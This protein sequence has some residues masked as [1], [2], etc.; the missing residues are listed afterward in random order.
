MRRS[1]ALGAGP[2][3]RAAA[4]GIATR[5]GLLHRQLL[6]DP[7]GRPDDHVDIRRA[8]DRFHTEI[9]WLDSHHSFTFGQ[10]YDPANTHYGLLLVTNDD[11]VKPGTGFETHPHRD[12]E[13]VTWVLRARS[14]TRTPTGN[15][16]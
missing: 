15:P 11:V 10:H 7:G 12:M 14:S 2:R 8:D 16:A 5:V 9:G 1:V 3:L 13:I 6:H 4:W